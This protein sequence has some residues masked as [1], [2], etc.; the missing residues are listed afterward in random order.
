MSELIQTDEE[1]LA[2]RRLEQA[3]EWNQYLADQ[4]EQLAKIE[5]QRQAAITAE[6][7][8]LNDLIADKN[9]TISLNEKIIE[10]EQIRKDKAVELTREVV[11]QIQQSIQFEGDLLTKQGLKALTEAINNAEP[12][13]EKERLELL[14][15]QSSSLFDLV[16]I[17]SESLDETK[18]QTEAILETT[19]ERGFRDF[20]DINART[21]FFTRGGVSSLLNLDPSA[22]QLPGSA[23]GLV[24]TT[25]AFKK[26]AEQRTAE[27]I[28]TLV[29]LTGEGNEI[30]KQIEFNTRGELNQ[31]I[32]FATD[33]AAY[34]G[35]TGT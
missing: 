4:Q 19:S 8:R 27:G 6:N 16:N 30:L 12:G 26:A 34:A 31:T 5:A 21:A 3:E 33:F 25:Q 32:K 28:E 7:D 24:V 29:E 18:K 22:L 20:L 17:Q 23:S 14:E 13:F 15:Q 35:R 10:D 2:Q 1:K 11:Q 9:R